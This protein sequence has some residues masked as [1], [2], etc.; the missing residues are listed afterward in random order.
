LEIAAVLL[1]HCC[2]SNQTDAVFEVPRSMSQS[3][4]PKVPIRPAETRRPPNSQRATESGR[5]A[6]APRPPQLPRS[7][8][9]AAAEVGVFDP[10]QRGMLIILGLLVVL[11]IEAYWDMFTLTAAAWRGD[12]LYSHGWIVP[13]FAVGLMWLR[14]QPFG[15][16][17]ST[18]RTIGAVLAVVAL[19]IAYCAWQLGSNKLAMVAVL[20]GTFGALLLI[21]GPIQPAP[22]SERWIGLGL[23]AFGLACR[24]FAA[25]YAWNPIDRLSLLPSIFG[26]FMLVGGWHTIRWAWPGL[27]FL[28]FMFPL[29]S[30]LEINILGGLQKLATYSSTFVLQTL[31]V[32]AMRSGNLISIPGMGQPLN[33]AEACAGLRMATIFG[34]LAVAMVFVIERPWWDKLVILISAAP[35]AIIVNIVRITVTAL[36]YQWVGQDSFAVKQICH[37]YAGLVIMMP[38]AMALLWIELQILE[39][40]TIPVDTVQ[41]RPVGG[42]RGV[43]TIPTR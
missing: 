8:V 40:V 34:A 27:A 21:G 28:I 25:K 5:A 18:A 3:Q 30:M 11:V 38:L 24:L 15:S 43:A 41:L 14:W 1:A 17:P 23:L 36:L 35:I 39:R 9:A 4:P 42:M 16:L 2:S 10:S 6:G 33:V 31:G 32:P 29:P 37:N 13:L 20:P 12:G 26:V 19:L 22:M 7:P